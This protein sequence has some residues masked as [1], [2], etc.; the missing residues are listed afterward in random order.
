MRTP[1]ISTFC[2]IA[3]CL[4]AALSLAACGKDKKKS[5]KAT[6]L[7]VTVADSG[8]TSTYT[9]QGSVKGGLVRFSVDNTGKAPHAGQL[10]RV[11]GNH[12]TQEALKAIG[13]QSNKTPNWIRG[14]GGLGPVSPGQT[15]EATINLPA[16]KYIVTDQGGPGSTGPPGYKAFTVTKGDN[17]SLPTT[18]TTITAANPSKDKFKWEINGTLKAGANN[19]TFVSKGKDSI[20]FIG[21]FRVIGNPSK[22]EILKGLASNGPPPKFVDQ[23]SFNTTAILDGGKSQTTPL[24]LAKPGTWVLFCPLS[25]RDGGK[26]HDQEGLLTTVQVG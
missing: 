17:G 11:V 26:S 18:P 3:T 13:S 7:A 21:A 24:A 25:D 10:V 20:H 14:E 1:R 23:T 2:L 19:V 16:G 22:A 9:V 5:A 4:V 12:T 8:K 15:A 6:A